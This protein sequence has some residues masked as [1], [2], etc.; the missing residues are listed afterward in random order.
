[1]ERVKVQGVTKILSKLSCRVFR[2]G[3]VIIEKVLGTKCIT[4]AFV[5]LLV[6]TLIAND[7]GIKNFKYHG[8]GTGTGAE[9]ADDTDLGTEVETRVTGTQVEGA[10]G[11][12]YKSVGSFTLT[13]DHTISEHGL[14]NAS[15]AGTLMDRTK[16][17]ALPLL[18]NDTIEF[19]YEATFS[20]GG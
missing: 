16:F 7:D 13:G 15:E 11:N 20:S 9:S 3:E 6:D 19:T 1:M 4:D 12:I 17:T 14:F 10:T 8:I 5:N 18:T 2:D